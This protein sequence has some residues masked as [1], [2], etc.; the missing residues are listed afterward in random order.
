MLMWSKFFC[1]VL[2]FFW[3]VNSNAQTLVGG[4]LVDPDQNSI[5]FAN[6]LVLDVNDSSLIEGFVINDGQFK[7]SIAESNFLIK[8]KAIGYEDTLIPITES[9]D[10]GDVV[11]RSK[12]LDEV[13]VVGQKLP[14]EAN[15][16]NLKI[17][18]NNNVFSV[19]HSLEEVLTKSPGVIISQTEISVVGRGEAVVYVDGQ[20]TS[21]EAAKAIPVSLIESIEVVKNPDASYDAKGKA[22]ILIRLKDLGLEGFQSQI[23]A[24]YTKAFYHLGF[25]DFTTNM[26]KGKWSG[27]FG[28]NNNMGSTGTLRTGIYQV[29]EGSNPY[30]ANSDYKEKVKLT[31]VTNLTLGTKYKFNQNQSVSAQYTG[32]YSLFDLYINTEIDQEFEDSVV[33]ITTIDTALSVWKKNLFSLNYHLTTD[34]LGSQ[35]FAGFNFN[36]LNEIYEDVVLEKGS[37]N[38]NPYVT[39]TLSK[40]GNSNYLVIGQVDFSKFFAS[41]GN[42]KLGAK[43]TDVKTQ[44]EYSLETFSSNESIL[45][46]ENNF[47]YREAIAGTY[48]NWSGNWVKGHYQIGTR[49]EH[50]QLNADEGN[51]NVTY[52]DSSY[53]SVF[54]NFNFTTNLG[55]WS[56]SEQFN[57]KISRPGYSEFT[58]YIFYVSSFAAVYG[59]PSI[60][61]SFVYTLEHKFSNDNIGF[62]LGLGTNY[63]RNPMAFITLQSESSVT[64]NVLQRVNLDKKQ[65]YYFELSQAISK[66]F[67][68]SYFMVNT[69]LIRLY[70]KEFAIETNETNPKVYFY[71]YNRIPIKNWF[72]LECFGSFTSPFSDGLREMKAQGDLGFGLSKQFKNWY[73]QFTANDIFQLAKPAEDLVI[74][75]NSYYSAATLDTRF[76]RFSLRYTFG[77]LKQPNFYHQNINQDEMQR[78]D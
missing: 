49:I 47:L 62:S 31:N 45:N 17:N 65:E 64:P 41:G 42:L 48:V 11:L 70:D 78:I 33:Q 15:G 74:G 57:S 12:N 60:R 63:T 2:I 39:N 19:C 71:G 77:K 6:L 24:D 40:G 52:I 1:F 67:I 76:F 28:I 58:P 61:P 20:E 16:G 53:F 14:F 46:F 29:N 72:N 22:V 51:G 21:R 35:F 32:S 50:T 75:D 68:Y 7:I 59:N 55:K 38:N 23:Y 25:I 44:S 30:W 4:K 18:V 3:I 34:T 10:L 43:Y 9:C 37:R 69:S 8:I 56:L 26:N 5:P 36:H 13:V 66:K 27:S 73:F 54:P